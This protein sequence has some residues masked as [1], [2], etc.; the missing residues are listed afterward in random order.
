MIEVSNHESRPN[1]YSEDEIEEVEQCPWCGSSRYSVWCRDEPPF[2]TVECQDCKVIYVKKRLNASGREKYYAH[3]HSEIH[4]AEDLARRREAMY[5]LELDFIE[6]FCKTGRVL[7]VGCGGG[8]FL[9]HFN[10]SRWERWGTE[11]GDEAV[12][13][14]KAL[15]GGNIFEGDLLDIDLP[16]RAF[17]LIVFRGVIE[18]VPEPKKTLL[19]ALELLKPG[20]FVFIG[21]TPNRDSVCAEVYREKW[22][23]HAPEAH[24]VHFSPRH[25][26]I[27]FSEHRTHLVAERIFYLETPY[28]DPVNDAKKVAE[29][30]EG[31]YR[32]IKP[33]EKSPAFFDNM[34]TLLFRRL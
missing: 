21:S 28:A 8:K 4:Q 9:Q 31:Y 5:Q 27:F 30:I 20:G 15:I 26:K 3:Y 23:Q 6:E 22:N 1:H 19:K 10:P 33:Q 2:L 13:E 17:D 14:A 18:H 32:R 11:I 29:S 34:M 25:F 24:I 12:R 16:S 7:D